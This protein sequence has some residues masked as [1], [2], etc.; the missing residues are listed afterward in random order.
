M[1][2]IRR[3]HQQD[4]DSIREVYINA[5]AS[6]ENKTVA[7]LALDLLGEKTTPQTIALLAEKNGNVA[8]HIA[9]SPVTFDSL[10]EWTGY[11]LAPLAVK[12]A[13]QNCG[14]GSKLVASGVAQLTNEGVNILFVYGDPKYY[15]K[16]GFSAENA[17]QYVPPYKLQYP[18]GW[19][20]RILSGK[21]LSENNVR[22]SCVNSL[23]RPELW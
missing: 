19:L 15:N 6:E 23:H 12:P 18:F 11:I 22:I 14:I 16:F 10:N 1:I 20:A 3:T 5:F 17:A 13:F 4:C 21:N 8:G 9:F 2:S 7:S